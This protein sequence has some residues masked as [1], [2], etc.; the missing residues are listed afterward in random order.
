MLRVSSHS[1]QFR[2][3]GSAHTKLGANGPVKTHI[4]SVMRKKH[5]FGLV[6]LSTLLIVALG[7]DGQ[8]SNRVIVL[9][10]DGM[11][12]RA[13]DLLMSE[14]KL[15]NFARLRQEGSYGTLL[16]SKPMLSP[17]L[18]TT[19]A[20]GK[21]PTEHGIGHF[22]AV[23]DATGESLPVTSEMRRVKAVWNILSDLGKKV[24]VVGWW[25]TWP[26]EEVNGAIVSD[27][28]CY[29]FLFRQGQTGAKD[30]RG[31]TYPPEL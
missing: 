20:T 21:P 8:S 27:H 10:L 29:H 30:N 6:L 4:G 18:W 9:G 23:N 16:S 13:I 3:A 14:G 24:A 5:I 12:P 7:C 22:V 19:M 11:D 28:T 15:P 1:V 25:A 26:A 31:I 17:L 2:E